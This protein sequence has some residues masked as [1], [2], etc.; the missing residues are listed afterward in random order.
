MP[1]NILQH[2]HALFEAGQPFVL[3]TVVR[4]EKPTSAKPGAKA[5]IL[6][7]G[8]LTGWIGGSCAEP[9]A[10]REAR[11]ALQDG[12]PR[13]LR[14]CPPEEM[15]LA[16]QE[17]V[18]EVA[19][20]CVSGGTLEIY[21][22]PHMSSPNLLV[23]G[24]M[25]VADALATLAPVLNFPVTVMGM[26]AAPERFPSTQRVFDHLDFSQLAITP[27]TFVVVAS[28]GNY[29]EEALEFALK[30]DAAYVALVASKV[31]AQAV[32]D[33]LGESGLSEAQLA[34]L[35]YPA[36][37]D[38]GAVTPEEIALS[39]LAEVV[40]VWRSISPA[41]LQGE[42]EEPTIETPIEVRDPVC[43]MMVEVAKALYTVEYRGEPYYFCAASC[44]RAFEKEPE[45]YLA[46]A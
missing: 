1:T 46:I 34:R 19:L 32:L 20:T 15:G 5:I 33:Y 4:A 16:P 11:K 6:P 27:R 8:T 37:L 3:A 7:D 25:A 24:H 14:L 41:A 43:G 28:H 22:E 2:S 9:T 35:K 30:S 17:G 36:G 38:F 44:K 40:Q 31:R 23:I 29:D 18:V 13:L 45:K 10:R 39:I 21:L 26:D 12:Q 42:G